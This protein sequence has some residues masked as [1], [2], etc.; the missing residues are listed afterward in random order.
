[1]PRNALPKT[2]IWLS[3]RSAWSARIDGRVL[4]L[5]KPPETGAEHRFIGL[6]ER[7]PARLRQQVA[8]DVLGDE[9][10]KRQVG[11]ERPNDVVAITPGLAGN[12]KVELVAE[13]LRV[14]HQ[15]EPVPG[16]ALG[17]A[18]AGEQAIDH[19]GKRARRVIAEE[20]VDFLPGRWQSVQVERHAPDQR[21]PI[22]G[23]R[24]GQ[25]FRFQLA[26]DKVVDRQGRPGCVLDRRWGRMR[27][28][29]QGPMPGAPASRSPSS[30][31]RRAFSH[32][33]AR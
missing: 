8:G 30:R 5:A 23:R 4:R 21:P 16:P 11:V 13:C 20:R 1:M 28:R 33:Q 3:M 19:G 31:R 14:A 15:V 27:E 9:A 18:R 26:Q 32:R 6:V 2:S 7:V 29:L 12:R 22:G 25:P 24:R 10:I 17:V